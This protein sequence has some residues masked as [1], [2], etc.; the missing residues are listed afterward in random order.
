MMA[1]PENTGMQNLGVLLVSGDRAARGTLRDF[2]HA[3]Q[4]EL[5]TELYEAETAKRGLALLQRRPV[6]LVVVGPDVLRD[7][8]GVIADVRAF[9]DKTE[10]IAIVDGAERGRAALADGA[11]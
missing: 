1:M 4:P 2:L 11:Y 8:G 9:D 7:A 10:V 3:R 5:P 6:D